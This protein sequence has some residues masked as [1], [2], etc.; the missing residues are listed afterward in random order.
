MK[1]NNLNEFMREEEEEKEGTQQRL[2]ATQVLEVSRNYFCPSKTFSGHC[3]R[4]WTDKL[5]D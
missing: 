3:A 2:M 4:A 1:H 5:T